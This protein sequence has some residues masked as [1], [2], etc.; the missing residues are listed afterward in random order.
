MKIAL[1]VDNPYRD[2][3]SLTLLAATLCR[4]GARV[5]LIPVRHMRSEVWAQTPDFVLLFNLRA[6]HR[7]LLADLLRAGIRFGVLDA[8]GGVF[9]KLEQYTGALLRDPN[10]C[11][12]VSCFCSWGPRLAEYAAREWL[13]AERVH[14]TGAPRMDFYA[15]AWREAALRMSPWAGS[16]GRPLVLINSNFSVANRWGLPS[17]HGTAEEIAVE[18]R[19]MAELARLANRLAAA[20]PEATFVYR[21]H[22]FEGL[23]PYQTLLDQRVNL[24]LRKVGT[25]EGWILRACAVVQRGCSTAIEATAAGVPALMPTWV[26]VRRRIESTEAVSLPCPDED[27]VIERVRAAIRGELPIPEAARAALERIV[28]DWFYA[29]DGRAHQRV[30]G[31]I[32]QS[33][34]APGGGPTAVLRRLARRLRTARR[35]PDQVATPAAVQAILEALQAGEVVARPAGVSVELRRP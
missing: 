27:T 11:R 18:K 35:D 13:P 32:L 19:G 29:V 22:P 24:Q 3:P 15:P 14:V 31:V 6:S 23:D 33:V 26:P 25:V 12:Q 28:A 21:P 9:S 4:Q 34:A 30:A 17:R 8:E 1:L 20:V 5:V 16:A 10:I 7:A 2:L